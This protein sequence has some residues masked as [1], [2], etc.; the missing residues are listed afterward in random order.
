M[1][2]GQNSQQGMMRGPS[3]FA[4]VVS[5]ERSFLLSV[6]LENSGVQVQAVA[7]AARRHPLHLP[8][9]QRLEQAL[10][11]T[12]GE[13]PEQIADRVVGGKVIDAQ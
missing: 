3:V 6:A 4:R 10:H 2:F 12:H 5:F 7:F 1:C 8:L 11:V 9:R 13:A